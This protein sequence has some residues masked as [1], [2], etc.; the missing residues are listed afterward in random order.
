MNFCIFWNMRLARDRVTG[1]AYQDNLP[2]VKG[3]RAEGADLPMATE[4]LHETP[5][6]PQPKTTR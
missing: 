1:L 5:G 4:S 3:A 6:Q 2:L